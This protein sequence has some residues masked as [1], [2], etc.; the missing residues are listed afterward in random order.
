[1]SDKGKWIGGITAILGVLAAIIVLLTRYQELKKSSAE[2]D[3]AEQRRRAEVQETR[4]QQPLP[5]PKPADAGATGSGASN[6]KS[7]PVVVP[8]SPSGQ[9]IALGRR[10]DGPDPR[11]EIQLVKLDI[12]PGQKMRWHFTL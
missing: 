2:A 8:P 4:K 5:V 11:L 3:L 9:T 12:E 7:D 1:M 6:G 10:I